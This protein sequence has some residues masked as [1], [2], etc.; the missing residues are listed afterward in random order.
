MSFKTFL[1]S[2]TRIGFICYPNGSHCWSIVPL[3]FLFFFFLFVYLWLS[4]LLRQYFYLFSPIHCLY[5]SHWDTTKLYTF[6]HLPFSAS[7]RESTNFNPAF[8]PFLAWAWLAKAKGH[9]CHT[10]KS[11]LAKTFT[12]KKKRVKVRSTPATTLQKKDPLK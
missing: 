3:F 4:Y 11:T 5:I 10:K 9:S 8:F 7:L 2:F 1:F 6:Q 12:K